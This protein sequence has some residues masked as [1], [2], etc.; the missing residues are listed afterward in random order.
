MLTMDGASSTLRIYKKGFDLTTKPDA[1][2]AASTLRNCRAFDR[3]L[4]ASGRR[5][6]LLED[7]IMPPPELPD[8]HQASVGGVR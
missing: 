5:Q 3:K 2:V 4:R 6:K 1:K 7:G 8:L